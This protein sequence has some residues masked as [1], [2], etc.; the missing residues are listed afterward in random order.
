MKKTILFIGITLVTISCQNLNSS[1]F[2][3]KLHWIT[4][5]WTIDNPPMYAEENWQWKEDRFIANGFMTNMDDTIFIEALT[6]KAVKDNLFLTAKVKDQNN[7]KE[8]FFKLI[9]DT[10]DSLLFENKRHSYPNYIEYVLQSDSSI[11]ARAYGKQNG[12]NKG[13]L[14]HYHKKK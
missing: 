3:D 6:I 4:G 10:P 5:T 13:D 9:S 12:K 14:L 2:E 11:I 8:V 7:N 1:N